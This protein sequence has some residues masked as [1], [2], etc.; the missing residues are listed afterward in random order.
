MK[1]VRINCDGTMN[2]I[3]ISLKK[4]NL[5]TIIENETVSKG[6]TDFKELY[7]WIYDEK[8][9]YCYGWY[10]G[11]AGFENK[12]DLI[13]NGNSTFLEED[14]SEK[15]LFGDIILFS[16]KKNKFVNFCVTDYS[17]VY[18]SLFEFEDILNTSEEEDEDEDDIV[19]SEDEDFIVNNELSEESDESYE[20]YCSDEELDND[21]NEY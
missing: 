14:S 11:E 2:D 3:N 1:C 13:P 18:D 6:S 15:L 4:R 19:D 7:K 8:E 10:D 5:S 12:H 21:D 9:I 17:E 16:M 20:D